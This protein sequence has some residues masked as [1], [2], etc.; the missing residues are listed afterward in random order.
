MMRK[1]SYSEPGY[2]QTF[3]LLPIWDPLL[4]LLVLQWSAA[5]WCW[6]W[7]HWLLGRSL[8]PLNLFPGRVWN[9][10][11]QLSLAEAGEV[12]SRQPL[13]PPPLILLPGSPCFHLV[14]PVPLCFQLVVLHDLPGLTH[15]PPPS[16]PHPKHLHL[17]MLLLELPERGPEHTNLADLNFDCTRWYTKD[18]LNLNLEHIIWTLEIWNRR[19][20][21]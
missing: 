1:F 8:L 10:W 6:F 3:S 7:R 21:H 17:R 18:F 2:L 16:L 14:F 15:Q 12:V 20:R 5:Y 11:L 9:V 13:P 19:P 4:L